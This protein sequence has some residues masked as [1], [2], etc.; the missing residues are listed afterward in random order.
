METV[1]KQ[2]QIIV[3][4]ETLKVT[5]LLNN[6]TQK[7]IIA[8][9][10]QK[11]AGEKKA[12]L[13]I[14]SVKI[15]EQQREADVLLKAAIPILKEAEA[16]LNLIKK[17]DLV[18]M[19]ALANPPLPVKMVGKCVMILRPIGNE[20]E[21][22]DWGGARIM[23]NDPAKLMERLK[24]FP[25]RISEVKANQIK[26]IEAIKNDQNNRLGEIDKISVAATGL[27][28]WVNSTI[29][30]YNVNKDVEPMKLRVKEMTER[31]EKAAKELKET[32]ELLLNL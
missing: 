15:E 31:S 28:G 32:E 6:I 17:D 26:K 29:K 4:E 27:L 21:G 13:D 18:G 22:D 23:M 11:S 2:K 19:K 3:N 9:E 25:E 16:A 10:A 1:L 5:Q 30:L 8:S 7:N 14:D 20:N 12:Q 24:S